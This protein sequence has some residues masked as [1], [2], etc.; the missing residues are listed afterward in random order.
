M[1]IGEWSFGTAPDS[2]LLFA[3]DPK[4]LVI[5]LSAYRQSNRHIA[6]QWD[7]SIKH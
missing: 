5:L 1:M 6:S 3:L 4:W 7:A 2:D